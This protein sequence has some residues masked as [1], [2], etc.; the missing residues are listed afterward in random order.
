MTKPTDLD[1]NDDD[2][3]DI[4]ARPV[5]TKLQGFVVPSIVTQRGMVN[6]TY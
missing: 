5:K 6:V 1:E 3:D 4:D 2:G